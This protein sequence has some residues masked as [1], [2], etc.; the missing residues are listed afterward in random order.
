[1]QKVF[2]AVSL[3]YHDQCQIPSIYF[4][5]FKEIIID[6]RGGCAL[7]HLSRAESRLGVELL[8]QPGT[9]AHKAAEVLD[10]PR[11]NIKV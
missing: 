4:K 8:H 10:N 9:V 5:V 3:E 7:T 6:F 2:S 1:M 11:P